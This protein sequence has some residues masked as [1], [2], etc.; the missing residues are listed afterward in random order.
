MIEIN[1]QFLYGKKYRYTSIKNLCSCYEIFIIKITLEQKY[2]LI[3]FIIWS[4][5]YLLV[6]YFQSIPWL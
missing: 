2:L 4:F 5:V 3:F 1:F 6:I